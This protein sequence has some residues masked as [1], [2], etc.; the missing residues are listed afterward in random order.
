MGLGMEIIEK[1]NSW[2]SERQRAARRLNGKKGGRPRMWFYDLGVPG[3]TVRGEPVVMPDS[4]VKI[5]RDWVGERFRVVRRGRTHRAT[6][7]SGPAPWVV[8]L[9]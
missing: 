7:V 5:H 1:D 4:V 3:V 2:V 6:V 8:K 9:V